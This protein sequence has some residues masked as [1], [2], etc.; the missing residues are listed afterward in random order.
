MAAPP[1][2]PDGEAG[3]SG[4]AAMS[5]AQ[6]PRRWNGAG[7]GRAVDAGSTLRSSWRGAMTLS[8]SLVLCATAS[9]EPS[10]ACT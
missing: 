6:E 10:H 8:A 1:L 2:A 7:Q 4:N 9:R 5:P 3:K